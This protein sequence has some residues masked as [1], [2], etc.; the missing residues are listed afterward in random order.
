V[1]DTA[2]ETVRHGW[3]IGRRWTDPGAAR[4]PQWAVVVLGELVVGVY[5]IAAWEPTPVPGRSDRPDRP[6]R[7]MGAGPGATVRSTYRHSFI[8]ERDVQLED[9][10][11]GRSVTAYLGVR[12]R[13]GAGA[14]VPGGAPNRVIYVGCGP[15]AILPSG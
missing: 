9:R 14:G 13:P 4:S 2:Y 5:R 3:R 11:L 6:D 7:R 15:D 1:A 10:Y 8:G 12:P